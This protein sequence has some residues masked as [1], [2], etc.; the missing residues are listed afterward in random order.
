MDKLSQLTSEKMIFSTA[1]LHKLIN[2][3]PMI[4]FKAVTN[5][6]H[7]I[8]MGKLPQVVD[9]SLYIQTIS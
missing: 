1:L 2:Q 5:Q 4:I 3:Q 6:L 7:K 9:L 8:R